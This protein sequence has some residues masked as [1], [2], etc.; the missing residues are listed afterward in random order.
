MKYI[1]ADQVR[2]LAEPFKKNGYSEYLQNLVKDK[3]RF[4]K[5]KIKDLIILEPKVFGDKRGYFL[6][7]YNKKNL[8]I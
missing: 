3:M 8:M 5:T 2:K 6:E 7:S 1:D 4:I